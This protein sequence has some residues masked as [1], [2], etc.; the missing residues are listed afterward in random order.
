M[1]TNCKHVSNKGNGHHCKKS[2]KNPKSL[3]FEGCT[4]Y[5]SNGLNGNGKEIIQAEMLCK[6]LNDCYAKKNDLEYWKTVLV[7]EVQEKIC[8]LNES[9]N[10]S[11]NA[12]EKIKVSTL[13]K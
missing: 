6:N 11:A 3:L 9:A 8:L 5:R 1:K 10:A 4:F 7:P 12:K 2:P 13:L